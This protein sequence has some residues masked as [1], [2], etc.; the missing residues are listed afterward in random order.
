VLIRGQLLLVVLMGKELVVLLPGTPLHLLVVACAR[1][2]LR[3]FMSGGLR[4]VVLPNKLAISAPLQN[5]G[6][7]CN[8][9]PAIQAFSN[10]GKYLIKTHIV[11]TVIT[12][13][14]EELG[15]VC[16]NVQ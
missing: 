3:A 11:P 7:R 10:D 2:L 4:R 6:E 8:N 13:A 1:P 12:V 9:S 15:K 14:T 16:S 5:I